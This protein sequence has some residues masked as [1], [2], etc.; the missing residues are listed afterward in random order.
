M[1]IDNEHNNGVLI[2]TPRINVLDAGNVAVFKT[3]IG[4]LLQTGNSL[5]INMSAIGSV[6][7]SG[8]GAL[9]ACLRT[10]T[11]NGGELKIF[12]I[13][14]PVRALFELVRIH[15]VIEIHNDLTET[16]ESFQ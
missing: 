13:Q 6:D 15:H 3:T 16:L 11:Q 14:K 5:A 8:L 7:S 2:L 4:P 1:Q 9:I 12:G 10:V